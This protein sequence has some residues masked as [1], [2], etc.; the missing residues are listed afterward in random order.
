MFSLLRCQFQGFLTPKIQPGRDKTNVQ[1]GCEPCRPLENLSRD[2]GVLRSLWF[3]VHREGHG[4]EVL[5]VMSWQTGK[6]SMAY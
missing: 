4:T 1:L 6:N 5:A 3:S 2:T